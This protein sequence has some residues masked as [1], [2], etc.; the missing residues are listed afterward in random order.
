MHVVEA[1][2]AIYGIAKQYGI[3]QEELI[4]SNPELENSI[5]Q[6]GQ[7]L[8]IPQNNEIE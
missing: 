7:K 8:V 6:A 5:L 3:S 4:K 2:E 1:E